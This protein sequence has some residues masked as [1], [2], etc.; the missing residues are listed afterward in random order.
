[1]DAQADAL[2]MLAGGEFVTTAPQQ[3]YKQAEE[4]YQTAIRVQPKEPIHYLKLGRYYH[5]YGRDFEQATAFYNKY[6]DLGG[7]DP[8]VNTWLQ[9]VGAQPRAEVPAPTPVVATPAPGTWVPDSTV[10]ESTSI[11]IVQ[12]PTPAVGMPGPVGMATTTVTTTSS[13]T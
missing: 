12:T 3:L 4:L 11:M 13:V 2:L 8:D 5:L 6:V 1:L 9:E 10:T 7:R